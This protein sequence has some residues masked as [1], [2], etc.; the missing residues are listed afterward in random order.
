LNAA[1][2]AIS[3]SSGNPGVPLF[4]DTAGKLSQELTA[5]YR[6]GGG[7]EKDV[8]RGLESLDPNASTETKKAILKNAVDLLDSK[9]GALGDQ[10]NQGMGLSE[11][12][13]R[14]LNSHAQQVYQRLLGP[15]GAPSAAGSAPASAGGW[16]VTKVGP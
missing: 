13:F 12:P 1:Q 16:T 9:L 2:N 11:D 15:S 6:G 8:V 4:K 14:L 10:Y 3:Q 7:A 5:V